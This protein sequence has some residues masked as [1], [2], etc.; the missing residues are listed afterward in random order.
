MGFAAACTAAGSDARAATR[1]SLQHTSESTVKSIDR[2]NASESALATER[3]ASA[4][5]QFGWVVTELR[6]IASAKASG[7]RGLDSSHDAQKESNAFIHRSSV[8]S[9]VPTTAPAPSRGGGATAI[10]R[11]GTT[12][13]TRG[14]GCCLGSVLACLAL[15]APSNQRCVSSPSSATASASKRRRGVVRAA[16]RRIH[17]IPLIDRLTHQTRIT[18]THTGRL[19]ST[20]QPVSPSQARSARSRK[21]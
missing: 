16:S 21:R 1:S 20:K 19:Q 8:S 6:L 4:R 13:T 15:I 7:R 12:T 17:C 18:H 11:Q 14:A 2:K 3:P 10:A 5:S 9:C